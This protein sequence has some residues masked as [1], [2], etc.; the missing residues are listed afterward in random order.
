[1]TVCPW[2]DAAIDKWNISSS[3]NFSGDGFQMMCPHCERLIDVE[4]EVIE[5]KYELSRAEDDEPEGL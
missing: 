3:E 4:V 5:V 1:M 2:C